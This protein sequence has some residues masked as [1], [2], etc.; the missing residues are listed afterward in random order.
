MKLLHNTL[1]FMAEE[2]A[3]VSFNEAN[4]RSAHAQM[5]SSQVWMSS[6]SA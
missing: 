1:G 3:N 4:N 5:Q 2:L 6:F